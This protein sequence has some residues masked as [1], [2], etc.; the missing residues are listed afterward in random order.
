MQIGERGQLFARMFIHRNRKGIFLREQTLTFF[1]EE[2]SFKDRPSHLDAE[3]G[4]IR[5]SW[6]A[7]Q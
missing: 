7:L 2:M 1:D 6:A 3:N 4:L 5:G